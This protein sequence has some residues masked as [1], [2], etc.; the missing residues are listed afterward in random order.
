VPSRLVYD[1][2]KLV[3]GAFLVFQWTNDDDLTQACH[4]IG[5][6]DLFEIKFYENRAN[7]QSRG[8][9]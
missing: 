4:A 7:G 5:V 3:I 9:V 2:K 8:C 6:T 1:C